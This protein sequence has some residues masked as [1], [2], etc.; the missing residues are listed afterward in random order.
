MFKAILSSLCVL[1]IATASHAAPTLNTS[2]G[3]PTFS[4]PGDQEDWSNPLTKYKYR[5]VGNRVWTVNCQGAAPGGPPPDF[6]NIQA[7]ISNTNLRAGDSI[8]VLGSRCDGNVDWSSSISGTATKP[9]VLTGAFEGEAPVVA[10]ASTSLASVLKVNKSYW[11]ISNLNVTA[12]GARGEAHPVYIGGSPVQ[13]VLISDVKVQRSA[14]GAGLLVGSGASYIKVRRSRSFNHVKTILT[15]VSQ[16]YMTK[17]TCESANVSKHL[18]W[19]HDGKCGERDDAHAFFVDNG[20]SNI[21]FNDIAASNVSGDGLQCGTTPEERGSATAP[22]NVYVDGFHA[23]G[24]EKGENALDI[25]QCSNVS[26]LNGEF[27]EFRPTKNANSIGEAIVVHNIATRVKIHG[28]HI[29]RSC[30]G[31]EISGDSKEVVISNNEIFNLNPMLTDCKSDGIVLVSGDNFDVHNNTFADAKGSAMAVGAYHLANYVSDVDVW[32]NIFSASNRLYM[33]VAWDDYTQGWGYGV[34]N[35]ESTYNLFG[36][37]SFPKPFRCVDSKSVNFNFY[38]T[39]LAGWQQCAGAGSDPTPPSK[40]QGSSQIF[41]GAGI[42][43]YQLLPTSPAVNAGFG[44]P[45]AGHCGGATWDMG[46]NEYCP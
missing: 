43:N 31:I 12:N 38:E 16:P 8:W 14:A 27:T 2:A 5:R 45:P 18:L 34:S 9:I 42:Y 19:G 3:S 4:L 10:P 11:I 29:S 13:R 28:N 23:N 26:L 44:S 15:S 39:D 33:S 7:A 21:S 46:A 20:A 24:R 17:E 30:V 40:V 1:L 25:K 37:S 36:T 32:N 22:F 35:F 41:M 6:Q